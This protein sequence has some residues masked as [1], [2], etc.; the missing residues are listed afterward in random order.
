M[1]NIKWLGYK[2][3]PERMGGKHAKEAGSIVQSQLWIT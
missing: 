1:G 3:Q 2:G